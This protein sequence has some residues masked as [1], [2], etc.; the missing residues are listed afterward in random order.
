MLLMGLMCE[1]LTLKS[2]FFQSFS[3]VLMLIFDRRVRTGTL[4]QV[5]I[6]VIVAVRC[7]QTGTPPYLDGGPANV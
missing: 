7:E 1:Y 2:C 3:L 5:L 6:F 4:E